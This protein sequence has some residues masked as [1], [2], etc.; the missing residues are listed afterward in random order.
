MSTLLNCPF[1]GGTPTVTEMRYSNT[2][3]LYGY[4]LECAGCGLQ[5]KQRPVGWPMGKENEAM[6]GAKTALEA[7]WNNRK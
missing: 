4:R 5:I 7:R 3:R 1:C 6:I 2:G